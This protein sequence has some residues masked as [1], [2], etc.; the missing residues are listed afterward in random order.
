MRALTL[1]FVSERARYGKR[2]AVMPSRFLFEM[3]GE[4]PPEDWVPV[5]QAVGA[6]SEADQSW[7]KTRKK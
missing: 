5:E 2:A 7:K 6:E 4:D 1:S 3:K